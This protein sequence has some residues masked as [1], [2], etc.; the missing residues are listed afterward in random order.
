SEPCPIRGESRVQ[1]NGQMCQRPCTS[2]ADCPRRRKCLCDGLC[3]LSCVSQGR[4]CLWP[5]EIENAE[6]R[7]TTG[8]HSFGKVA[9]VT[10]KPGFKMLEGQEV[11][12]IQCQGDRKWSRPLPVCKVVGGAEI[13]Q[14]ISCS[15]PD[16]I[17]NGF[18][19]GSD[20]SQGKSIQYFCH[21]GYALEGFGEN[22][23][24]EDGTWRF[25]PPSCHQVFCPPPAEIE[26]GYLVAVQKPQYEVSEMVYYLCKKAFTLDGSNRVVC[27]ANGTWSHK[28]TCRSRC[29]I[30]VK[31]SRFIY[32]DS[33]VWVQ[34]VV[35][36]VVQHLDT[37]S[38]Y[39]RLSGADFTCSYTV[40]SQCFDGTLPLPD[41][42]E[43]PTW[44]QYMLF[45]KRL[46]SEITPC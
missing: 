8:A 19:R 2:N 9:E 34:E 16:V 23:C 36:G 3:G 43:E 6:V 32:Y 11:T 35:D 24:Q 42:Y 37:V 38:F 39:C 14:E 29:K 41:C 25:P 15:F 30:P 33:K 27:L 46:V 12:W 4:T 18:Y 28:P 40:Q 13:S 20:F 10:C 31:R 17:E 7:L 22:Y 21:P 45:P 1:T 44:L 26:N 5:L